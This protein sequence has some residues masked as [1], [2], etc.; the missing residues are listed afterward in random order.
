MRHKLILDTEW[1]NVFV[2]SDNHFGHRFM[3]ESIR[4]FDTP[5]DMD[6]MMI[7]WWNQTV[8]ED[9]IVILF[10]DFSFRNRE[11]TKAIVDSL[12][13]EKFIIPGNHDDSKRLIYW[14]GEDHV[15]PEMTNVKI[16][17]HAQE[18]IKFVGCHYPLASWS[19]SDQ[20]AL[21]LHGHLHTANNENISHHFCAPYQ[22]AGTRFDIGID[23]AAWFGLPWS[24]IPVT[25]PWARHLERQKA[26]AEL[27]GEE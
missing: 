1:E 13:G 26:W 24:P 19:G 16:I 23:N 2:T 20:G 14:F 22:G 27:R 5:E 4:G 21:H 8:P 15:L 10:G 6:A 17:N 3:A 25:V 12:N 7:H 9:A 18:Q 11:E